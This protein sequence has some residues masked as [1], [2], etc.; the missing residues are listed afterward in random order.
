MADATISRVRMRELARRG[1]FRTDLGPL[2]VPIP[3]RALRDPAP[4]PML[5]ASQPWRRRAL[6]G[7]LTPR[8][9]ELMASSI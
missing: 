8:T 7:Q 4:A 6:C 5:E 3:A 1:R 2:R 9:C